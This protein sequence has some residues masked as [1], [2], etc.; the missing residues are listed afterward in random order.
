VLAQL[1]VSGREVLEFSPAAKALTA[2][3]ALL[4]L[5]LW[6]FL[7][8]PVSTASHRA[9]RLPLRSGLFPNFERTRFLRGRIPAEQLRNSPMRVIMTA[10]DVEAGRE[11]YFSN[12]SR[13]V[14]AADPGADPAFALSEI[15]ET[16][17]LLK[18][19][20]A[21]SASPS[22]RP[23]VQSAPV[24]GGIVANQPIHPAPGRRPIFL[25][26]VEL[27]STRVK[28]ATFLTWGCGHRHPDVAEPEDRPQDLEHQPR[29]Q[30]HARASRRPEQVLIDMGRGSTATSG[31]HCGPAEPL[32]AT[33]LDYGRIGPAIL[34]ATATVAGRP[35]LHHLHRA[36]V[37]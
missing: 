12:T 33:V 32:A 5:V 26:L 24:D 34:Q 25:V 19:V 2:A 16:D 29:L 15:H 37:P 10:A 31:I 3:G 9:L 11:S 27:T 17:D 36:P 30:H 7:R 22:M 23:A 13:E 20:L 8:D 28:I 14:L 35:R 1:Y 4:G 21:S 18:A 6:W